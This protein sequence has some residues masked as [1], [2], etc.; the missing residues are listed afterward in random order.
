MAANP[1]LDA[2]NRIQQQGQQRYQV[3]VKRDS[4][5]ERGS[6]HLERRKNMKILPTVG[7]GTRYFYRGGSEIATKDL[8]REALRGYIDHYY[9]VESRPGGLQ[10][11]GVLPS[12]RG[13]SLSVSQETSSAN[14]VERVLAVLQRSEP[15]DRLVILRVAREIGG[16]VFSPQQIENI[17]RELNSGYR[18]PGS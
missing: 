13:F 11:E 3:A 5:G 17:L 16:V 1:L 18:A 2:L 7:P 15:A 12:A 8:N 9:A 10:V 14:F 4:R 6:P